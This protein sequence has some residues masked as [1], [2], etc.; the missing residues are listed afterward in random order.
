[1]RIAKTLIAAAALLASASA[2][3][4]VKPP[5]SVENALV[6]HSTVSDADG[7][8]ADIGGAVSD[9]RP[10]QTLS[11]TGECVTQMG[12]ADELQVVLALADAQSA[13]DTG[14]HAV[15]ATDREFRGDALEVRVP[16]LPQTANRIFQVKIFHL[17]A[18]TPEICDAGAIRIGG[19]APGKVG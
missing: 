3:F 18:Q 11:I 7:R 6:L 19:A 4:A 5:V 8:S 14:F 10:G 12:S 2:A 9:V 17:G 16:E 15:I 1:M 13:G